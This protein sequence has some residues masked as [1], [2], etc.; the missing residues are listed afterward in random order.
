VSAD[1]YDLMRRLSPKAQAE[2]MRRR[3]AALA[4]D[5]QVWYCSRGRACNGEPH[6]E[7]TYP[8]ARA[9]QYPP[10]GTWWDNWF[11]MSG[12]GTGKT[13]GGSNWVRKIT[14]HVSRI[15]LIGRTIT[16][17]RQT[18]VEGD[19]GLIRACELAGETYDWKPALK[20]FT[21]QNGAKAFGWSAEE[22]N[23]L[24][25]PEHGAG[26]LDE[27][28]HW[29][30]VEETWA[31]YQ[32]GL[33]QHGLPGGAK[34]LLTSSPLPIP[35]TKDRIAE[36]GTVLVRVPTSINIHNLDAG[37]IRRVI[38]PLMGTRRGRQE[39]EAELLEDVEG[40]LWSTEMFQYIDPSTR[41]GDRVVV[42]VD[43][44]GSQG[45]ASDET[46]I[47]VSARIDDGFY[48]L[49]DFTGKYSPAGWAAQAIKAYE[50]YQAD[51]IV[52]ER[53][54]GGDMVKDT[55]R[56]HGFTGRVIEAKAVDGKRLRAEP[57]AAIYEQER[58]FHSKLQRVNSRGTLT[59][60]TAELE[61]EL[62]TWVPGMKSPNRLDA[63]V[64]TATELMR[65]K[66]SS[67]VSAGIPM[68]RDI[69]PQKRSQIQ[70]ALATI[71]TR[72]A[73]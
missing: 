24:R 3:A 2:V 60:V 49:D 5:R 25:G 63:M 7:Y 21:F 26:W 47:I 54:Y 50:M 27:P 36:D 59:G 23:K 6:D 18:M 16:D 57:I 31:N 53:N 67:Q 8:H 17:V 62:V 46:G 58:G 13:R 73:S 51:A 71:T 30:L 15:A 11:H 34:T 44:A 40:A 12:R 9:D 48:V 45:K 37:Y 55:L 56:N 64:W 4:S 29:D 65:Y 1:P 70:R 41:S 72:R 68:G 52:V 19:G 61:D 69:V 10:A 39:L 66:G 33:R 42:G 22:P 35:W 14:S 43:P 20:E 32:F 38:E 28:C